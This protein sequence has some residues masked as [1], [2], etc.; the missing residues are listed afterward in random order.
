MTKRF[1]GRNFFPTSKNGQGVVTVACWKVAF[2]KPRSSC[3][4]VGTR[5]LK[6]CGDRQAFRLYFRDAEVD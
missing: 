3:R 6:A 4:M 2:T 5:Q 1:R